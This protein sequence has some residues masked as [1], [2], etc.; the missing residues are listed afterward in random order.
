MLIEPLS[1]KTP[2]EKEINIGARTFILYWGHNWKPLPLTLN[3]FID[4]SKI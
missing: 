3:I 4:L 1:A 2:I